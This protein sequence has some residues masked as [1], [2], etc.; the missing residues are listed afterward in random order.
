MKDKSSLIKHL[1]KLFR[2]YLIAGREE[3]KCP[4]TDKVLHISQIHV[5]HFISR[6]YLP[7]RWSEDNCLLCS[8]YTNT[9]EN[10]IRAEGYSSLHIKRYSEFLGAEKVNDLKQLS[11]QSV[12]V[13]KYWLIDK[14]KEYEDLETN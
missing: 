3:I 7:L 2:E 10:G 11:K 1:D 5:C 13:D 14:I 12:K 6:E 8:A 9:I 4:L